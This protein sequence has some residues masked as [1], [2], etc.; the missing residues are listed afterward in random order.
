M[1]RIEKK[2]FRIGDELAAIEEAIRLAREELTFH[3]HLNDDAQRDAAVSGS[4]VD[5][6]D[7]KETESDVARMRDHIES[8]EITRTRLERRR[9]KLLAKLD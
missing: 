8:L 7:A 2:L 3:D 9:R 5:R 6:A 1:R 4:P